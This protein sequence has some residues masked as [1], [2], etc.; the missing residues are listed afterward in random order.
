MYG[1]QRTE[2]EKLGLYAC[3]RHR[4]ALGRDLGVLQGTGFENI[5]SFAY[6]CNLIWTAL[7]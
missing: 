2:F 6:A 4:T 7:C 5:A 3:N 1:A